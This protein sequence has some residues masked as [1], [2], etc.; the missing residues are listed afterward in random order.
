MRGFGTIPDIASLIRVTRVASMSIAEA[1]DMPVT[2][3][4]LVPPTP[5]RAPDDMT[6][7]GADE[8]DPRERDR[9]LGPAGL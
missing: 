6:H 5:P 7:A 8:G 4:P 3:A 9:Q 2:R 1:Y